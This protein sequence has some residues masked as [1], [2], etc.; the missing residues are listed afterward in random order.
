MGPDETT[1]RLPKTT[2]AR[3]KALAALEGKHLKVKMAEILDDATAHLP[4]VAR[5]AVEEDA[6]E[7]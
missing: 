3:V 1:V 4:D 5:E 2:V 7:E 6:P